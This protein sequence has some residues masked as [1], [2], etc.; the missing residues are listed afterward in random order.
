MVAKCPTK[1]HANND[2]SRIPS[3]TKRDKSLYTV[4]AGGGQALGPILHEEAVEVE[5]AGKRRKCSKSREEQSCAPNA[6]ENG[7][8]YE[9]W[10]AS[11]PNRVHDQSN[12]H[13]VKQRRKRGHL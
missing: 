6:R 5:G 4:A 11:R 9:T 1:R 2:R 8:A 7:Q 12:D 10:K 3:E 13:I